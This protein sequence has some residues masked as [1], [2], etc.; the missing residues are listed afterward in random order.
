MKSFFRTVWGKLILVIVCTLSVLLTGACVLGASLTITVENG[1]I[2]L[3][4][5]E[6]IEP[7][8]TESFFEIKAWHVLISQL[9]T[10]VIDYSYADNLNFRILNAE[11]GNWLYKGQTGPSWEYHYRFYG[12]DGP[13]SYRVAFT[14]EEIPSEYRNH[15][16]PYDVFVG[17][18]DASYAYDYG[19]DWVNAAYRLGWWILAIGLSAFALVMVCYISLLRVSARR[20]GRDDLV[21]GPL[22]KLPFDLLLATCLAA[23]LGLAVLIDWILPIDYIAELYFA[24]GAFVTGII[25]FLGLSM[26]A[27]ARIKTRTLL[28]NTLIFRVLKYL[29]AKPLAWLWKGLKKLHAFNMSILRGLPLVGK[30]AL[31]LGVLAIVELNVTA[32]ADGGP[33]VLLSLIKY[34]ILIPLVLYLALCLRRLQ[35][36][37]EALAA[38]DLAYQTDTKGLPHDL[39][40][41]A[42][43]LNSI[44]GG[45]AIAVR[46]QLKSERMKTELI[47][48]VSHDLKTPLTSVINYADLIGKE[49]CENAK[50]KEYSGVL[51]RQSERLK[52]LIDDLVE[53]SKAS[54]GNL[55]VD[56]VPCDASVFLAQAAGE[57]EEKLRDAGLALVTKQPDEEVSI[58]ADGRRMWRI[59]D[60]L[61]NNIVK[62]SLSGTRVYLSLEQADGDAVITF[63]NTSREP[64]DAVNTEELV[65]RFTRGD[66]SRNTEGSGLGLAIAKSL[67]ELQGGKFLVSADGDLFKVILRFPKI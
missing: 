45:M 12:Y 29:V 34:L 8:S 64:L 16:I 2:H 19:N 54:T 11:S 22:H 21:P 1:N 57:Y 41:H 63:R 26:S 52:R 30:T 46:E 62:Y 10:G 56:L 59:F 9:N 65:E 49:P 28:R 35:K 14:K 67:T 24:I 37:G 40:K 58:M 31:F 32:A 17:V 39:K 13:G 27:A 20:S 47:T 43:D 15:V 18:P 33:L 23:F 55:E 50:I 42:E 66:V 3:R 6:E 48:N 44:G 38:G 5:K 60:N 51:L 36:G 4:P 53:A 7:L 61:M 25:I